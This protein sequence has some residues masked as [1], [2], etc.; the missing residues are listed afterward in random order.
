[1]ILEIIHKVLGNH[2]WMYNIQ[3]NCVDEDD[4]WVGI[5][6]TTL[7]TMIYMQNRLKDYNTGQLL[8]VRNMILPAKHNVDWG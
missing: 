3:E 7:F 2:V 1:M 6:A 4:P 8:F 5:L